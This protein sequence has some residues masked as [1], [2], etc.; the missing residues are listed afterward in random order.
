M[1]SVKRGDDVTEYMVLCLSVCVCV[2]VYACVHL[3]THA[4]LF[5]CV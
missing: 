1:D 2:S 3:H 5:S 4:H